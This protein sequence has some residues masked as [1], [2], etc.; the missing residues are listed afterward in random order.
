M[1]CLEKLHKY[2][3]VFFLFID[4]TISNHFIPALNTDPNSASPFQ[5]D[6]SATKQVH[7]CIIEKLL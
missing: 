4:A 2:Y 5:S 1:K 3:T 7:E 6:R